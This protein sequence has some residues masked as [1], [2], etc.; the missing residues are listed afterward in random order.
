MYSN[1]GCILKGF[2]KRFSFCLERLF[3]N[4]DKVE[5]GAN[6]LLLTSAVKGGGSIKSTTVNKYSILL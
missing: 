4:K 2:R 3:Q 6:T 5:R 1:Q